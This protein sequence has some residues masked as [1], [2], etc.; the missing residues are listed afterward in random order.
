M[1]LELIKEEIKEE[2]GYRNKIY[3]DTL[4]F[5]TI[6]YGHLVKPTDSFKEGII[7]DSKELTRIF[8]YDFQIAYQDALSLTKDLDINEK[9]VE[10]LIHMCFQLGKPKV[11]KFQRMF[12]NLRKKDY[13]NAGFEMEDSRWAKQT[14]NRAMRLSEKMK[15]LT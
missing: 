2:E 8:E 1:N 5:A 9:A 3:K 10:I 12:D 7:Y 13:V 14:P 6:G 4:G 15:E 11:M